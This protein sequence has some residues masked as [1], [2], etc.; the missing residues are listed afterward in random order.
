M[1]VHDLLLAPFSYEFM[2]RG[3]LSAVLLAL[4]LLAAIAVGR[5][6]AFSGKP[7]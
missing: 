1:S 6:R 3:L 2:R 7:A 4:S 5:A